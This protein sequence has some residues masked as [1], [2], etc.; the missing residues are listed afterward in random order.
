MSGNSYYNADSGCAPDYYGTDNTV[1]CFDIDRAQ[2]DFN[3]IFDANTLEVELIRTT[4]VDEPESGDFFGTK[5]R[6][7]IHRKRIKLFVTAQSTDAYKR[8]E[9]GIVTNDA[10]F[11]AF[12]K[13]NEDI[14]NSDLVKFIRCT[15][16]LK[17]NI[18][19]G[20]LFIIQNHNRPFWQ[21]QFSHQEFSLKRVDKDAYSEYQPNKNC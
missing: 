21:G 15:K 19:R 14:R 1:P 10:T 7:K 16:N 3:S 8:R 12:A 2:E 20:E 6:P 4:E 17:F 5:T 18:K 11:Q 9:H 13:H